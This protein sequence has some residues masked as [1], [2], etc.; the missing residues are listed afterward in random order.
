MKIKKGSLTALLL[1]VY[2]L[3]RRSG[4]WKFF[5]HYSSTNWGIHKVFTVWWRL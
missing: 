1:L 4:W 2:Q 5:R 3:Q